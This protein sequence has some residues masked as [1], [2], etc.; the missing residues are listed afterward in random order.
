[1]LLIHGIGNYH[2]Q[3]NNFVKTIQSKQQQN[4]SLPM[5]IYGLDLR[6]H[7]HSSGTKGIFT[8]QQ[9]LQ[10]VTSVTNVIKQKYPKVPLIVIGADMV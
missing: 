2:G 5:N 8:L 3:Y 7:G 10:D 9:W 1:M 6:G 4:K